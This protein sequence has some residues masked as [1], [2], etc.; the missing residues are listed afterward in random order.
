MNDPIPETKLSREYLFLEAR[1]KEL[2]TRHNN[3]IHDM[4]LLADELLQAAKENDLCD[5]YDDFVERLN[6]KFRAGD[7]LLTRATAIDLTFTLTVRGFAVDG[8]PECDFEAMIL[9]MDHLIY[10][11]IAAMFNCEDLEVEIGS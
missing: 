7:H 8:D 4:D 2:E 6:K 3:L 1:H 11:K 5:L 10:E 9:N